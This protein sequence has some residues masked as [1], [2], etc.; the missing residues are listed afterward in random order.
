MVR[1]NMAAQ[2]LGMS[3]PGYRKAILSATNFPEK[4]LVEI[5]VW[6]R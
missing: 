2:I 6:F 3:F 5:P 1:I 4:N